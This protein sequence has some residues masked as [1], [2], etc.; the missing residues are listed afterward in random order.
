MGITISD[1]L[2][3]GVTIQGQARISYFDLDGH[4]VVEHVLFEGEPD[5][6]LDYYQLDE[7]WADWPITYMWAEAG[8]LR[9]E[10]EKED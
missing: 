9:I 1:M 2:G 6:E 3:Q 8:C 7:D 4:D 10:L 5:C